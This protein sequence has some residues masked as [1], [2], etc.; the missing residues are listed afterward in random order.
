[1]ELH[2]LLSNIQ[3]YGYGALFFF[4]WLGIAGMP[5]PDEMVVM[6]GGLVSSLGYLKLFPAFLLT[7]LGV[8]SGLSL[9]YVLGKAFGSKILDRLVKKKKAAY[10]LKS[11]ELIGK[12][13]HFALIISYFIPVIRHIIPY[14]V[15]INNM[16]YKTYALYSYSTGLVWTIL[17]FALGFAFGDNIG[18]IV[19]FVTKYGLV[20]GVMAAASFFFSYL[21]IQRKRKMVNIGRVPNNDPAK[22]SCE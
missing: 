16:P 22:V 20:F 7:Y 2:E 18:A 10:L 6:S 17:Y 1:M 19:E 21:T 13:G 12:Y 5:I 3:D 4:L 9:G 11:Q 8:V 15:G 14:I